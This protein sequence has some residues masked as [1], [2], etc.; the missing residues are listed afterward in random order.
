MRE[1]AVMD[2]VKRIDF[3]R[4]RTGLPVYSLCRD[5]GVPVRTFR[6]WNNRRGANMPLLR[7]PGPTKTRV[8][9]PAVLAGELTSLSHG[10][11][12]TAGM[13]LLY[14]KYGDALS[15]REL[16]CLAEDIRKDQNDAERR[17]LRRVEWLVPGIIWA[18][19]GTT[20]VDE[21]SGR[22]EI[23]TVRDLGSKYLFRPMV[24]Q[25][26]PCC[27]E[28]AGHTE[29]L[30]SAHD[31]PLLIKMDNGGNLVGKE[32]MNVLAVRRII[33]LI[34]PPVY[35]R[36]NG[37][38]EKTQYDVKNAICKSL[39]LGRS[40]PPQEFKLHAEL[41]M[42]ELNHRSKKVLGGKNPCQVYHD[43]SR[44][45]WFTQPER[46]A[47]YDW[48]NQ[49]TESILKEVRSVTKQTV[50][51]ARR[52]AIEAWLVKNNIIRITLNGLNVTQF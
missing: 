14:S 22:Q 52:K 48:I 30:T 43:K 21:C 16:A 18:L 40:V 46:K 41:A 1:D 9:D 19:D 23:M 20:Y 13:G 39:P 35:P 36:Y 34:S 4:K 25:W 6:R 47:I 51:T 3:A 45:K 11:Y 50:A 38:L 28:V 49:T 12:R 7:P 2:I 24:T 15:R 29:E 33:P 31:Q 10:T 27:Q 17:N 42:H 32:H 44:R 26:T 5:M 37:S 8:F